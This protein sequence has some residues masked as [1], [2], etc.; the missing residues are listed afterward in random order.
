MPRA[1]AVRITTPGDPSVLQ[2]AEIEVRDP[3]PGEILVDVAAA[4]LNRA[5][6]LQRMG[7]YPPP[8]GF[9]ADI[10]GLEYA[11]VIAAIGPGVWSRRVGERVMG[12]VGGGGMATRVVVHEREAIP[13]PASLS[14]TDA[15]A[16][17]EVFLTAFDALFAQADAR[18]GETILIHAVGSGVGT[19]LLQLAQAAGMSTIG[20]SRTE[21]KLQRARAL[22][23][24]HG[25]VVTGD[26]FADRVKE[27]TA[28]RGVDVVL[29]PVAGG[30][31]QEELLCLATRGRIVLYGTMGG[32]SA[33]LPVALMLQRRARLVGTTLRARPLEEKALLAQRFTREAVPLF[34]SGR[35]KPIVQSVLP[36]QRVAEAHELMGRNETFG[37]IVLAWS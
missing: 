22:G 12:V 3:G 5:D 13:V 25:V 37:K 32:M 4:G 9:P 18:L 23:L 2:L 34:A 36:M 29:D 28:G 8:P 30:Y 14:L 6:L 1:R 11:G 35:V 21:D 26:A 24:G 20:T 27:I 31:V 10:P 33:D 15:A 17:P 16:I 19:A 7:T